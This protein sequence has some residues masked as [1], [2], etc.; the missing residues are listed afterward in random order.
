M[1]K[2]KNFTIRAYAIVLNNK[3]EVLVSDEY[4]FDMRI[5]KFPGG[6]VDL[7]EGLHDTLKREFIEE[8]EQEIEIGEHFYTTDFY[9]QAFV[10]EDYQLISV[11]YYVKLKGDIKFK[12]SGKP[13]DKK[14]FKA[15]DQTVRWFPVKDLT[16]SIM[17][18]PIDKKVAEML[19]ESIM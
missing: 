7:G 13:F 11:Y 10:V 1:K 4:A 5:T 19:K 8:F 3:N 16:E 6:G 2:P 14:D 17:T 15:G 12:I 9:Q 18:F